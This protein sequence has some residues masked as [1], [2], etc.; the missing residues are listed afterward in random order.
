M[1]LIGGHQCAHDSCVERWRVVV[2][3]GAS[4]WCWSGC[5]CRP[6]DLHDSWRLRL[7]FPHAIGFSFLVLGRDHK[8]LPCA[9]PQRNRIRA[10]RNVVPFLSLNRAKPI[11]CVLRGLRQ[12]PGIAENIG[13][14]LVGLV[15]VDVCQ[16]R[17]HHRHCG[18]V[19]GVACSSQCLVCF[20][21]YCLVAPIAAAVLAVGGCWSGS[22]RML[23]GGHDRG[24]SSSCWW[25]CT[26]REWVGSCGCA[27]GFL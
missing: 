8:I 25:V 14:Y 6:D 20:L 27:P 26:L 11:S 24:P 9:R 1:L 17:C 5:G 3:G 18:V 10:A 15:H 7:L 23:G 21:D 19:V 13:E 22:C 4:R 2:G 12:C 16:A